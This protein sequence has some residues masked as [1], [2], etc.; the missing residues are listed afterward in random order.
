MSAKKVITIFLIFTVMCFN[1]S[2]ACAEDKS[3]EELSLSLEQ[4][5]QFAIT[6]SYEVKLA[7][8]DFLIAQTDQLDAE[9]IYDAMLEAE[10]SYEKDKRQGSSSLSPSLTRTNTYSTKTTK[11]LPSGTELTFSLSDTRLW[12]DSSFVTVN[13][14]HTAEAELE[15][16]QPIGKNIF[17]YIDRRDIAKTVLTIQNADLDTKEK[18]E[19]LLA[20]ID[21]AYWEWAQ[22]K[23]SLAIYRDLLERANELHLANTRNYDTGLIEKGDFLA[24]Q[25]NV[26]IREKELLSAQNSYRRAEEK[27]KLLINLDAEE[28]IHP[29]DDLEYRA[30][31][32][33]LE[34]CLVQAFKTRRDYLK[35]KRDIDI[36]NIVLETKANAR[37]PEIDLVASLAANGVDSGFGRALNNITTDDNTDYYAGIEITIPFEN[38]KAKAAFNKAQ[39]NK[40]KA[41]LSL[42]SIERAIVT[43]V[44]DAFRDYNTHNTSLDKLQ[45]AMRLELEK[46][47]EEEKRF[48]AARSSTKRLIDY[49]Q[50]YLYAQ[51]ALASG[52][53]DLEKARV[54]LEKA[55]NIILKKHTGM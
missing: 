54:N 9:S 40:E 18:I 26:L 12:N 4:C 31:D 1:V 15:A 32:F 5:I 13:P 23:K 35:A 33:L 34:D 3:E 14:S 20:K 38:R 30:I 47:K 22:A 17:G 36:K 27:V 37:W 49:Q 24:S 55:L 42:K 50:D 46:L 11:T 7:R 21:K 8:L 2:P 52:L 28:Q 10:I 44:G 6:N 29:K 16:R 25:A 41:I 39:H 43:E 45:E 19:A 48:Q 53:L 51:L